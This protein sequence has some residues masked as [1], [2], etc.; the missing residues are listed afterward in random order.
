MDSVPETEYIVAK[1]I[2]DGVIEATINH[3]EQYLQ[4]MVRFLDN[5]SNCLIFIRLMN[6]KI[7]FIGG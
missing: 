7:L 2:R 1:A 3:E 5:S 4:T 6:H